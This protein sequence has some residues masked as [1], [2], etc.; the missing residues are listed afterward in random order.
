VS[1]YLGDEILVAIPRAGMPVMLAEVRRDGVEAELR[2]LGFTGPVAVSGGVVA[3][4]AAAVPAGGALA[5]DRN[6]FSQGV[7]KALEDH[8]L[9]TIERGEVAGLPPAAWGSVII[10]TG[11]LTSDKLAKAILAKTDETSLAFFDAIAPIVHFDSIDMETAWYQ[12]RWDKGDTKDYINCPMD[13]AEYEA[14]IDAMLAGLDAATPEADITHFVQGHPWFR[15]KMEAIKQHG[16]ADT[17][18]DG[19]REIDLVGRY[20]IPIGLQLDKASAGPRTRT[21][22]RRRPAR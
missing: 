7:T 4:G 16:S 2:R 10:A 6:I 12:S 19:S 8:P 13:K 14:F 22:C 5:V 21:G 18:G 17:G 11:P 20:G 15:A 9:V 3:I 1:D